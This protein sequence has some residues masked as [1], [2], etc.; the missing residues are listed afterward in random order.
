MLLFSAFATA[1]RYNLSILHKKKPSKQVAQKAFDINF[2]TPKKS[3]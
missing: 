3:K 2:P 1:Q